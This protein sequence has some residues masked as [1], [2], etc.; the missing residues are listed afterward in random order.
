MRLYNFPNMSV[1]FN[2]NF[3][4]FLSSLFFIF[5]LTCYGICR[6]SKNQV[7]VISR[8]DC[9]IDKIYVR[10][11]CSDLCP[12]YRFESNSGK[13]TGSDGWAI[14]NWTIGLGHSIKA[15]FEH[16]A[17]PLDSSACPR[18]SFIFYRSSILYKH[19]IIT[20]KY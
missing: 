2:V 18:S 15:K 5:I 6:A 7:H 3:Q 13:C 10:S 8:F 4:K 11:I 17:I 1:F 9:I 14:R 16:M 20:Y 12:E 19:L